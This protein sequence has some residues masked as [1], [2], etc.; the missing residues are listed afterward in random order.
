MTC[1]MEIKEKVIYIMENLDPMTRQEIIQLY[2]PVHEKDI[3]P[4]VK[5][6]FSIVQGMNDEERDQLLKLIY[7]DNELKTWQQSEELP[8]EMV[9]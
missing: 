1:N 9:E 7:N 3:L 5:K 2:A 8:E 4:R 6:V